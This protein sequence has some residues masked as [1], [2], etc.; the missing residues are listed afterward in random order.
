MHN[1]NSCSKMCIVQIAPSCCVRPA[2]TPARPRCGR[3][4]SGQHAAAGRAVPSCGRARGARSQEAYR[5]QTQDRTHN[6]TPESIEKTTRPHFDRQD[7]FLPGSPMVV[8]GYSRHAGTAPISAL[9][10]WAGVTPAYSG[11]THHGSQG[12]LPPAAPR[13]WDLP[14][15]VVQRRTECLGNDALAG[16]TM[17][18][19][20]F[21]LPTPPIPVGAD[22][23]S[24]HRDTPAQAAA[25]SP[26][27]R[28]A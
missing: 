25:S 27:M 18:N 14:R 8:P 9:H 7:A 16:A 19:P 2:A 5:G 23:I 10:G 13:R 28:Y 22:K 4:S 24:P 15:S 21:R 20:L 17:R 6:R 26:A 12:I 11:A 1:I 3:E